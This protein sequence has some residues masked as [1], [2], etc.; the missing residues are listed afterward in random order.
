MRL[1][2]SPLSTAKAKARAMGPPLHKAYVNWSETA[3]SDETCR[4]QQSEMQQQIAKAKKTNEDSKQV[5][6]STQR[7]LICA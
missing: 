6:V 5:K 3:L 1:L 2:G 7:L 4:R